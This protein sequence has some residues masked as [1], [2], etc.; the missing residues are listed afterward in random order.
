M[1]AFNLINAIVDVANNPVNNTNTWVPTGSYR[2]YFSP[3]VNITNY[4]ILIDGRNFYDQQINGQIKN[5]E[6]TRKIARGQGDDYITGCLL[7]Y[8]YLKHHHFQLVVIHLSKQ[9]EL[10]A[11]R[12]AT[13]QIG[14]YGMLKTN[15]LICTLSKKHFQKKWCYNFTKTEFL[16]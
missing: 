7:D 4:S 6:E 5:Y 3:R 2:K 14:C 13:Q 9:K 1:F 16:Y 10:D 11:D 15:S 12:R 8:D